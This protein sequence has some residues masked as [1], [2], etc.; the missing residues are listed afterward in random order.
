MLFYYQTIIIF[1][2]FVYCLYSPRARREVIFWFRIK[3]AATETLPEEG[4]SW[5][6]WNPRTATMSRALRRSGDESRRWL[7]TVKSGAAQRRDHGSVHPPNDEADGARRR[8]VA[9]VY[10]RHVR[11]RAPS[12][13]SVRVPRCVIR[14]SYRVRAF[15]RF[16]VVGDGTSRA[17]RRDPAERH[18]AS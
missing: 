11:S 10:A 6:F 18:R 14:V 12:V 4:F 13:N 9:R 5:N 2:I 1:V 7:A 16:G 15:H 3:F 8:I 17:E